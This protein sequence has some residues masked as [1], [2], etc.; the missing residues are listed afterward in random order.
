ME[1]AHVVLITLVVYKLIL[2]CIGIWASKRTADSDD[3][4]LGGRGTELFVER[5]FSLGVIRP[6]RH[7]LPLWCI[8][9]LGCLR[10]HHINVCSVVLACPTADEI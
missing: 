7:R 3:F 10:L 9:D 8:Y 1:K 6:Y 5:R 4:F 2:I